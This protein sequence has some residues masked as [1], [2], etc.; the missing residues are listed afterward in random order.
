MAHPSNAHYRNEFV[1]ASVLRVILD[2][3]DSNDDIQIPSSVLRVLLNAPSYEEIL[4]RACKKA[5]EK[6]SVAGDILDYIAQMRLTGHEQ[7]SVRKA[8]YVAEDYLSKAVN[9]YGKKSG[10]SNIFIYKCWDELKWTPQS[11]Q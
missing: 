4:K 8:V 10:S 3:E 6:G 2:G 5:A 11:R 1:A 9:G 7:P